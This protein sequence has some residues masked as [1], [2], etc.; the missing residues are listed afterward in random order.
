MSQCILSRVMKRTNTRDSNSLNH[1]AA[2][3]ST[4]EGACCAIVPCI[5]RAH[6]QFLVVSTRP[7]I[8]GTRV[9]HAQAHQETRAA[10]QL[11]AFAAILCTLVHK[12]FY[13]CLDLVHIPCF[14]DR[15]AV[16]KNIEHRSIFE[17]NNENKVVVE[18]VHDP[19]YRR[20]Q[21]IKV[22]V[23]QRSKKQLETRQAC[24][25][26]DGQLELTQPS[27]TVRAHD[28]NQP[29]CGTTHWQQS[30]P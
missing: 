15:N 22:C 18:R 19:V 28:L 8:R 17:Y 16:F 23:W 12:P 2:P 3:V 26:C 24:Q 21:L 27:D 20:N 6:T 4:S 13:L 7:R 11:D 25:E 30:H 1:T 10:L 14:C 5:D 29:P 9:Q